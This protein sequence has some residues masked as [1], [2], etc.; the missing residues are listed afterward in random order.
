MKRDM[1]QNGNNCSRSGKSGETGPIG[2]VSGNIL[3]EG[4]LLEPQKRWI[5][6][7]ASL[8]VCEKGRRTGITWAE[9]ADNVL[10]AASDRSAGGQNIYYIGTDKE[11]TEEYIDAC[12]EWAK[13]FSYAA[14]EIQSG[15]WGEGEDEDRHIQT[16]TIRFP[17]SGHKITALASR[18]RKLRGRQGVLV[19]DEAAFQDD[20]PELLKA[21]M[22]FM[23]WGGKV[24]VISTHD[25]IDNPFNELINE[26]RAG[27]RR[28]NVHRVSFRDAVDAGLY[29]RVCLRTGK[30]WS[31]AD[32]DEWMQE[33]YDSYGDF[34]EEELDCIP[35]QGSGAFLTRSL[36]ESCMVPECPVIRW[37]CPD[38][39][40]E[41][42]ESARYR[43]TA[44]WLEANLDDL[45]RTADPKK[46]SYVGMDFGRSGDLS[47]IWA[48]QERQDLGIVTPFVLEMRNVPFRQQEQ[49]LFHICDRLPRFSGGAL[50][51]RGNG[52]A[53][54]EFAMQ[55]YGTGRIAQVMLSETWYREN[56]PRVKAHFEDKTV[57]I[58]RDGDILDDFRAFRMVKGVARIPEKKAKGR[59][60][61][62]RH[63]D[64]GI[65]AALGMYAVV[66]YAGM[67][68][69]PDIRSAGR[70]GRHPG[71]FDLPDFI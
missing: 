46:P 27:K 12:S 20:L 39:Y 57:M 11:M 56:M 37:K 30:T 2:P 22:A 33:I 58:P 25:G 49:V 67:S 6:D 14:S 51:A 61:L 19:G 17:N 21:A 34:A 9:S 4:V 60:G 32:Q 38:G 62:Q 55:R 70:R 50:D 15:I 65:A 3:P 35:S 45:I 10:I 68:E 69:P 48:F 5:T 29:H 40:A 28:G 26:I 64:S 59:D 63:G 31:Q 42:Q 1:R 66:T 71:Y 36:I 44:D 18:P 24:R 41:V 7:P 52:Q 8:K 53:L 13:V 23:I 16:F 47:V 43:D 54:A